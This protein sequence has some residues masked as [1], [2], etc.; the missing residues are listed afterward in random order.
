[1]ALLQRRLCDAQV[2]PHQ[3]QLF[4]LAQLE[5]VALRPRGTGSGRPQNP[6]TPS[7]GYRTPPEP[8]QKDGGD[9]VDLLPGEMGMGQEQTAAQLPRPLRGPG[10][11]PMC[12]QGSS[13]ALR[14][15][16]PCG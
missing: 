8:S 5:S 16:S 14:G 11:D 7:L 6:D 9:G 15:R 4:L 12:P 13:G 3:Q 1:M 10:E 2:L